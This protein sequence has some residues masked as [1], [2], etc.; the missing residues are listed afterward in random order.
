MFQTFKSN[1]KLQGTTTLIFVSLFNVCR[2]GSRSPG[3]LC[4]CV[5]CSVSSR[6]FGVV[7]LVEC[8]AVFCC[9][10]VLCNVIAGWSRKI[11]YEIDVSL[12]NINSLLIRLKIPSFSQR[13]RSKKM[14]LRRPLLK[15]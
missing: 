5:E 6:C 1:C 10:T 15:T 11:S 13:Y 12:A 3:P 2:F 4:A 14:K 7:L 9:F 8:V